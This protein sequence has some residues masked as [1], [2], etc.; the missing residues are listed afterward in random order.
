L[1]HPEFELAGNERRNTRHHS[2]S[3]PPTANVNVTV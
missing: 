3:C 1:I 2:L